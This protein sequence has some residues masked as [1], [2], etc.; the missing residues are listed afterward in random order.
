MDATV[1]LIGRPTREDYTSRPGALIWFF[2]KEPRWLEAEAPRPQSYHQGI[3]ESD[4]RGDQE[5]RAV[6]SE[7]RAS[8]RASLGLGS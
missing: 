6:A 8:R 5:S 7:G 4:R 2:P 3:Q 1:E